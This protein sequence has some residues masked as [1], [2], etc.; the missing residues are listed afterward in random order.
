M[1]IFDLLLTQALH[2]NSQI[3]QHHTWPTTLNLCNPIK[4]QGINYFI[5][6]LKEA[7]IEVKSYVQTLFLNIIQ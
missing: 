4:N 3:V 7:K 1:L 5:K 6:E 2:R